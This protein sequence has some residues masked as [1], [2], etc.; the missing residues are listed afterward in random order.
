MKHPKHAYSI[1]A[2]LVG[3]IIKVLCRAYDFEGIRSLIEEKNKR[4]IIWKPTSTL[5]KYE[6]AFN[7]LNELFELQK[8]NAP[9]MRKVDDSL[10]D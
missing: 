3:R 5:A 10:K 9:R 4:G 2:K 8:K 7:I 6:E 1:D